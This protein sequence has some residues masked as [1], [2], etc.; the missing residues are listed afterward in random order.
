MVQG[1]WLW[2]FESSM[3]YEVDQPKDACALLSSRGSW[4]IYDPKR[5]YGDYDYQKTYPSSGTHISQYGPH[6]IE[7]FS[8][9]FEGR[10]SYS[11][12]AHLNGWLSEFEVDKMI[13]AKPIAALRCETPYPS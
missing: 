10:K 1:V 11:I 7:A 9:K 13:S 6:R 3:F 2:Q 8:I 12:S 4:L 5:I